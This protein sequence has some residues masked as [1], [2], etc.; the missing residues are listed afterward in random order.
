ML[1]GHNENQCYVLHPELYPEKK[2]GEKEESKEKDDNQ[3]EEMVKQGEEKKTANG[4]AK[5]KAPKNKNNRQ[6]RTVQVS[7][8]WNGVGV[9]NSFGVF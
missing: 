3:E 8:V 7:T 2:Q 9:R 6:G 1:Q 5:S 4:D